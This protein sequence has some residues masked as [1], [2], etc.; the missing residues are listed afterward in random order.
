MK[1]AP[2]AHTTFCA[3]LIALEG[4]FFM[5]YISWNLFETLGAAAAV[6]VVTFF[7]GIR[8]LREVRARRVSG[9]R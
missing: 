9:V 2:L 7:S 4:I 3:S 8:A 6:G 5:Y 1:A